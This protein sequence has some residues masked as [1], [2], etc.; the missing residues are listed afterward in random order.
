MVNKP[1]AI[2]TAG[3][4]AVRNFLNGDGWPECHRIAQTG[5]E[6]SGDLLICDKPLR[7]IAEV[8]S[9]AVAEK[10][11]SALIWAWLEE[12][13]RERRNADAALGVLVVRR[14]R[15]N[16]ALWDVHMRLRDLV[17]LETGRPGF[18]DIA[19]RMSLA[20]FSAMLRF[21]V[22]EYEAGER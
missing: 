12:T 18:S 19:V 3:E 10:A 13:E 15:R 22:G 7:A 17:W 4:S 20:D 21:A 6:D 1:K 8:K 5:R 14:Y 2:G 16:P 9:G 11:S